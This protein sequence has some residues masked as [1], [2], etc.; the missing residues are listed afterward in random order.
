[1]RTPIEEFYRKMPQDK[2]RINSNNK[3]IRMDEFISFLPNVTLERSRNHLGSDNGWTKLINKDISLEISGGIYNRV[4]WVD[5]IKYGNRLDNPYNDYVNPLYLWE[6]MSPEGRIFFLN[7]YKDEIDKYLKTMG[8]KVM[9]CKERLKESKANL[10]AVTS[11]IG[12]LYAQAWI[13][14]AHDVKKS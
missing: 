3:L 5:N 10:S 13:N 2:Y 11:E 14:S 8:E 12:K 1:M 7:Y 9:G 6:I 4:E